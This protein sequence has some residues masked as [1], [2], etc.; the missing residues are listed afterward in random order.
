[1]EQEPERKPDTE[2]GRNRGAGKDTENGRNR[3]AGGDVAHF[4][5]GL[6]V[7]PGEYLRGDKPCLPAGTV[8][9]RRHATPPT[10]IKKLWGILRLH[11]NTTRTTDLAGISTNPKMN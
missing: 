10:A 3:G 2:N 7:R 4:H 11:G 5:C 6:D 9:V 8:S 1:M